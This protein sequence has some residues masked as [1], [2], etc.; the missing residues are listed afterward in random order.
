[1]LAFA[2]EF[3][4]IGLIILGTYLLIT[5]NDRDHMSREAFS[6]LLLP[7]ALAM[8]ELARVPLAIAVRTQ[9]AW[10][11]KLLD[12]IGV[13]AAITVTSFSL[14]QIAWKTFVIRIADTICAGDALSEVKKKQ[15]TFQSE[16]SELQQELEEKREALKGIND[17]LAAL[18]LQLTKVS[19]NTSVTCRPRVG[20]DG[21]QIVG[22]N[23]TPIRDCSPISTVSQHS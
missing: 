7:A 15:E 13:L 1:V 14:S 2:V 4:L 19:S 5:E 21:A 10:H 18:Q 9:D 22:Q 17:R 20:A 6:A 16:Q 12:A 8:V 11:I 3:W 23:G